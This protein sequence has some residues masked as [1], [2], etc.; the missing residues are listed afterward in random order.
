[1]SNGLSR[2]VAGRETITCHY[3]TISYIPPHI[4]NLKEGCGIIQDSIQAMNFTDSPHPI[5]EN[6]RYSMGQSYI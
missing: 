4:C 6:A 3:I 5:Y 2:E 1:M